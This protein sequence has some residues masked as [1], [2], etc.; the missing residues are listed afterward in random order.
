MPE[1][2]HAWRPAVPG[3]REVFHAHFEQHAYPRH[4]H[5]VWTLLTVSRGDIR[6]SLDGRAQGTSATTVTL[7][8][9]HVAHD[10]RA[11]PSGGFTKQVL[12]LDT[13]LL[14]EDLIGHAVDHPSTA[15]LSVQRAVRDLHP[16]LTAADDRLEAEL[17]VID[18]AERLRRM[19]KPR[20]DADRADDHRAAASPPRHGVTDLAEAARA[21]LDAHLVDG[22]TMHEVAARLHASPG[23]VARSFSA[24]FRI[25][26]HAYVLGRRI[27]LARGMLL[28]GWPL[29]LVAA[30]LGFVD[31]AHLSRHF[32]RH[33]GTTPGRFRRT[34]A[35]SAHQVGGLAGDHP[36]LVGGHD[37]HRG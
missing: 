1:Q 13:D 11:G 6:F 9:P 22:I 14:G 27:D 35:G 30:Q 17:R 16:V 3:I 8:P 31:Q 25:A 15:D 10:G 29:A 2:V 23:H 12:Y 34:L 18:V 19:L 20:A 21:H 28:D 26:P 24:T 4:T 37:H 36:L 33:V 5:D 7:L 32:R